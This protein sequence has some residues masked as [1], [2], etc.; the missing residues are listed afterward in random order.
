MDKINLK[1]GLF[2]VEMTTSEFSE[3]YSDLFFLEESILSM[4]SKENID[5][6][7]FSKEKYM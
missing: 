2:E 5:D 6:F 3:M 1:Y 4:L 7:P